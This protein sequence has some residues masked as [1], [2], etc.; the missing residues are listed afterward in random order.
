[1][2]ELSALE[3][4]KVMKVPKSSGAILHWGIKPNQANIQ[5]ATLQPE[6]DTGAYLPGLSIQLEVNLPIV[7]DRCRYE[8]GLFRLEQ[9]I[10]RRVYQLAVAPM[11]KQTHHD[12][13]GSLF[14]PHEHTGSAVTSVRVDGIECGNLQAAFDYFCK[15]INLT[16]TGQANLPPL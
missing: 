12:K 2:H 11:N 9:G 3:A 13:F 15:Q 7:A 10:R 14:G 4:A 16:F 1:M 6:D 5:L 8:L